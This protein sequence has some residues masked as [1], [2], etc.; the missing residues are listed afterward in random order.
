MSNSPTDI[1]PTPTTQSFFFSKCRHWLEQQ[2]LHSFSVLEGINRGTQLGTVVVLLFAVLDLLLMADRQDSFIQ[3]TFIRGFM[4]AL[5]AFYSWKNHCFYSV[6]SMKSHRKNDRLVRRRVMIGLTVIHVVADGTAMIG[7]L[8]DGSRSN[9]FAGVIMVFVVMS[10]LIPIKPGFLAFNMVLMIAF[11]VGT[12]YMAEKR[13]LL[14][15]EA[16]SNLTM[17]IGGAVVSWFGANM[18]HRRRSVEG[19]QLIPPVQED[20]ASAFTANTQSPTSSTK[21]SVALFRVMLTLA[22]PIGSVALSEK[23]NRGSPDHFDALNGVAVSDLQELDGNFEFRNTTQFP[24]TLEHAQ[25]FIPL[26]N[27]KSIVVDITSSTEKVPIILPRMKVRVYSHKQSVGLY[28]FAIQ[29]GTDFSLIQ[30]SNA[31]H[32]KLMG[33][34]ITKSDD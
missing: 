15:V 32:V 26:T 9:Y 5:C 2:D 29:A 10:I 30:P 20:D 34:R 22:F 8:I 25:I 17:V 11:Y 3:C 6:Q 18:D 19:D 1:P 21:V 31:Y 23:F 4:A 16:L 33:Y 7:Y 13:A 28:S 27:G 12:L 14:S 24:I